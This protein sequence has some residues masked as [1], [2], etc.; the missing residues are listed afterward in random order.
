MNKDDLKRIFVIIS[1][2]KT[3][4]DQILMINDKKLKQIQKK[5][6]NG[7]KKESNRM[8]RL[9]KMEEEDDVLCD[10]SE[11][12]DKTIEQIKSKIIIN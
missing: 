2:L 6:F 10:I 8:F 5:T 3:V 12:I 11:A 7:L 9:M 1:L 4:D